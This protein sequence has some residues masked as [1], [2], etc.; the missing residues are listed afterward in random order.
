[1]PECLGRGKCYFT[2]L[3]TTDHTY[4]FKKAP[5]RSYRRNVPVVGVAATSFLDEDEKQ[6]EEGGGV[7]FQQRHH[8]QQEHPLK[9]KF[10]FLVETDE[11]IP[12]S[13][14]LNSSA[15]HNLDAAAKGMSFLEETDES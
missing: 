7:L 9:K 4:S 2:K 10:R 8:L 1:M 6:D 14:T 5:C 15:V 11:S 3:G 12:A 13:S